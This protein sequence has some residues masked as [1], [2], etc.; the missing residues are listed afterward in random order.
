MTDQVFYTH[1]AQ[2]NGSSVLTDAYYS[3]QTYRLYLKFRHGAIAGYRNVNL[4]TFTGISNAPS[5]GS[6]YNNYIKNNYMTTHGD[7]VFL[8]ADNINVSSTVPEDKTGAAVGKN[9]EPSFV[10]TVRLDGT[11]EFEVSA[12]DAKKAIELVEKNVDLGRFDGTYS[13]EGVKKA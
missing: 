6:Y 13:V 2:F 11:L 8:P 3:D 9:D 5:A 1:H 10:V 12:T 7:V 4:H